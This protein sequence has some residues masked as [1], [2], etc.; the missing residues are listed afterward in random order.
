MLRVTA[1]VTRKAARLSMTAIML[2]AMAAQA[3]EVDPSAEVVA[4][5]DADEVVIRPADEDEEID[6]EEF[7]L[8]LHLLMNKGLLECFT[9]EEL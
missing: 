1:K 3:A 2:I 5:Y 9:L 4:D 8:Q 7:D 6:T